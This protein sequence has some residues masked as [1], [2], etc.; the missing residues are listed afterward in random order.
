MLVTVGMG[1]TLLDS[2]VRFGRELLGAETVV[3]DADTHVK[4][5]LVGG[6]DVV[7]TVAPG[8]AHVQP[9]LDCAVRYEHGATLKAIMAFMKS[10]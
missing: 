8:E 7:L 3:L 1:E 2:C 5:A 6:K 4:G 10:A 9:A